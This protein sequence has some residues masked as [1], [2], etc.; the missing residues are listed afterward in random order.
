MPQLDALPLNGNPLL[1]NPGT[2]LLA[3]TTRRDSIFANQLLS[4][5]GRTTRLTAA[6]AVLIRRVTAPR[7]IIRKIVWS[8]DRWGWTSCLCPTWHRR[9]WLYSPCSH[10]LYSSAYPLA[11][12]FLLPSRPRAPWIPLDSEWN[13]CTMPD[14]N[15]PDPRATS[16]ISA[17]RLLVLHHAVQIHSEGS[18]PWI[19]P[20]F[21]AQLPNLALLDQND[22]P[23]LCH[24][25]S[26]RPF[27]YHLSILSLGDVDQLLLFL[28][29][30]R[31]CLESI[32]F[33]QNI[34]LPG[35]PH[36]LSHTQPTRST[37]T[38]VGLV[39]NLREN[40]A[41]VEPCRAQRESMAAVKAERAQLQVS[42][43]LAALPEEQ[44]SSAEAEPCMLAAASRGPWALPECS[45]SGRW[46]Y[47]PDVPN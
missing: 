32:H 41:A 25:A 3:R 38:R 5:V 42:L 22:R 45:P 4:S 28:S 24:L 23:F 11:K 6:R 2:Q 39:R 36:D 40:M 17:W 7:P 43:L 15:Y 16:T 10:A 29:L 35:W 18:L 33:H 19:A 14:I 8:S 34:L 30:P 21:A 47:D 20:C 44:A 46:T 31:L 26:C 27:L 1:Q 12:L 37:A 9:S 13:V